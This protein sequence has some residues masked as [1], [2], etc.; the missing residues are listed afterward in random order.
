MKVIQYGLTRL[1]FGDPLGVDYL[2]E[3]RKCCIF[4]FV[5]LKFFLF[6]LSLGL[7]LIKT[8]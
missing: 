2:G 3:I 6:N 1:P 5:Y 8:L 4:I 7:V